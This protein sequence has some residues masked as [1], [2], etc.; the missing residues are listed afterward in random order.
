MSGDAQR[1][2]NVIR[3]AV[4]Q[5]VGTTGK[6][7]YR[8]GTIDSGGGAYEVSAYL[9]GDDT[10][11]EGIRLGAGE[12]VPPGTPVVVIVTKEGDSWVDQVLPLLQYARIA[13]D[14]H[15]GIIYLGDGTS[16]PTYPGVFGQSLRSG[17]PDGPVFWD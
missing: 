14:V 5:E 4:D 9:S 1:L 3:S 15:N 10:L 6:G 8:Y 7:D 11:T 17:G 16:P 2:I 13:I 12:Y